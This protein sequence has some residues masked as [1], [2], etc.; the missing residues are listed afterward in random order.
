[1]D[2]IRRPSRAQTNQ[3]KAQEQFKKAQ[4]ELKKAGDILKK[5]NIIS[6]LEKH[7]VIALNDISI[8]DVIDIIEGLKQDIT[9]NLEEFN[10][11]Q[12][13]IPDNTGNISDNTENISDNA[14]NIPD[15]AEDTS[16]DEYTEVSDIEGPI[17]PGVCDEIVDVN[18]SEDGQEANKQLVKR[19]LEE[20]DLNFKS[21]CSDSQKFHYITKGSKELTIQNFSKGRHQYGLLT[22]NTRTP[23]SDIVNNWERFGNRK[24][25]LKKYDFKGKNIEEVVKM[26]QDILS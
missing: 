18:F 1:M 7:I 12:E 22:D 10:D 19:L 16:E 17:D 15:N 14:E 3:K 23:P 6:E 24:S 9:E 2:T 11:V 13:D 21:Q 5:S 25:K 4:E 26:I 20:Q 8:D